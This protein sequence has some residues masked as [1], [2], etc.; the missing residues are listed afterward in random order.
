MRLRAQRSQVIMGAMSPRCAVIVLLSILTACSSP[1]DAAKSP[2]PAPKRVAASSNP[3]AKYI[4]LTGL[5]LGEKG[6]GKLSVR[7]GAVNHSDADLGDLVMEVQLSATSAKAGEPP[8]ATF[9][10]KIGQLGPQEWKDVE[11]IVPTKLRVYELPDW[12]YVKA[13]FQVTEPK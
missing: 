11:V 6:P 7:F 3:V 8:F 13:D 5:R 2:A 12:Q 9:T 4:E 1:P 10:A